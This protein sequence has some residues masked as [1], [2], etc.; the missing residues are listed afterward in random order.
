MLDAES[1]KALI[2]DLVFFAKHIGRKVDWGYEFNY[3]GTDLKYYNFLLRNC[4]RRDSA[5]RTPLLRLMYHIQC[6]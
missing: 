3:C 4:L 2:A 6:S 1:R 5:G